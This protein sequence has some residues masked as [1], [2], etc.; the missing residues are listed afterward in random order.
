MA[1]NLGFLIRGSFEKACDEGIN[2]VIEGICIDR[3]KV[4]QACHSMRAN[5]GVVMLSEHDELR[6]H[7][8]KGESAVDLDIEFPRIILT[9]FFEYIKSS[10]GK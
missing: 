2:V 4:G 6:N 8:V 7:K 1:A 5:F 3:N 10:L 9:C